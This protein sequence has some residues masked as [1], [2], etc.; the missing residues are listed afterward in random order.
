M[1]SLKTYL[2]IQELCSFYY[3]Q[4]YSSVEMTLS[5]HIIN[6]KKLYVAL[7]VQT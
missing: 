1:D 6:L 3:L 2:K 5:I 4:R 7:S